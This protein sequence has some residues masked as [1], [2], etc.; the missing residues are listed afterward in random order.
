M[1]KK[2]HE[3]EGG[4]EVG[5]WYVSFADMITLLLS[6]F[7]MMTS[8]SSF[9]KEAID[10]IK[11]VSPAGYT[12]L[13]PLSNAYGRNSHIMPVHRSRHKTSGTEETGEDTMAPPD[14]CTDAPYAGDFLTTAKKLVVHI[15]LNKLFDEHSNLSADGRRRLHLIAKYAAS[16]SSRV[17]LSLPGV[18]TANAA[19]WQTRGLMATR[20]SPILKTLSAEMDTSR[21]GIAGPESAG[22]ESETRPAQSELI[23]TLLLGEGST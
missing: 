19:A 21:I 17:L 23:V 22:G 2:Q 7:V 5:L 12:H 6:F 13:Y 14:R 3:E 4:G 18:N 15:P 9:D 16:T 20:M 10:V 11:Q 8:F 1:P